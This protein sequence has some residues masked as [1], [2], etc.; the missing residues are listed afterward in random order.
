MD[1][2]AAD[3]ADEFHTVHAM[4]HV[5]QGDTPK[6]FYR[7]VEIDRS[8]MSEEGMQM[9]A[10][11]LNRTVRSSSGAEFMPEEFEYSYDITR[12]IVGGERALPTGRYDAPSADTAF[13]NT[14]ASALPD[15]TLPDYQYLEGI[16]DG[17]LANLELRGLD[18]DI[19]FNA[20]ML[21]E[22]QRVLQP[23]GE[24]RIAGSPGSTAEQIRMNLADN[25][26]EVLFMVDDGAFVLARKSPGPE[27]S[28]KPVR[29]SINPDAPILSPGRPI[30][31]ETLTVG[32][33]IA[34]RQP[35][36]G[37]VFLS[38]DSWKGPHVVGDI[39]N[40]SMIPDNA[41][42]EISF[43]ATPWQWFSGTA[44]AAL[45]E[46]ARI[47]GPGGRIRIETGG[48]AYPRQDL[49]LQ[50]MEEAG[51][52]NVRA[53]AVADPDA[54]LAEEPETGFVTFYGELPE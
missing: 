48:R 11:Q 29:R 20:E 1:V 3:A 54:S 32:P 21:A 25:D 18:S 52:T 41:F 43:E 22:A 10:N 45:R 30:A 23:N 9:L 40:A 50:R 33:G 19:A 49:I 24:L 39:R 37:E 42:N 26:L 2:N 47:V 53:E 6:A 31:G 7:G 12:I 8:M 27:E 34:D 17:A 4:W 13:I 44:P 36:L 46:A 51:F 5:R 16:P 38:R 28:T 14:D 35:G 15:L